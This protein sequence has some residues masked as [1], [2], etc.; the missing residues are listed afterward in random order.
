MFSSKVLSSMQRIPDLDAPCGRRLKYRNL[1]ECGNTWA[2]RAAGGSP[3]DNVPRQAAT[4]AA[5]CALCENVLDPLADA[6]GSPV[7]TYGFASPALTALIGK[8]IAPR[9]DQ[10]ASCEVRR[11][12]SLICSRGGASVDLVVPG[13]TATEVARWLA[14][15][16]KFDRIY[17]YGDGR[18]LHISH[19]PET[20]RLVYEMV[21][22]A[23][24]RPIPRRIRLGS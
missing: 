18:P 20:S 22:S 15:H 7:L 8:R 2:E 1:I 12:G 6:L 11:D 19:G 21:S 13:R 4:Y 17:L 5:L 14:T 16:T 3:I 10:H 24:G 23:S 9:L